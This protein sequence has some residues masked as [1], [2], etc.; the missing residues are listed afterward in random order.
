VILVLGGCDGVPAGAGL[1][2][3]MMVTGAQFSPGPMPGASG[4]PAV[5]SLNLSSNAVRAG[6]I[7]AP[8]SGALGP[9][10]T[11]A[12]LGLRGDA[13][14]WIVPAGLPDVAAPSYPTFNVSL[15][16]SASLAP[17]T[18]DL[19]VQAV[20]ADGHFGAPETETLTATAPPG[21]S[22]AMVVTL[23][24]DTEADLDLH[25]VDPAGRIVWK[26]DISPAG[27]GALLDFDSNAGC[28]VDGRR[29]ED[30]IWMDP[31]MS[32]RYQV[33]VD[34]FSLCAATFADWTV[35]VTLQ[36]QVVGRAAGESVETDAEVPHDRGAGVLALEI[37]VP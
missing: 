15:S 7:E 27:S 13:G 1:G 37:D 12:S 6:E 35:E 26:G 34:T 25:V 32:G 17:G 18:Y 20:D 30:V 8:V 14:Y 9:T 21:P 5:V 16:F 10:A 19:V 2:A 29:Q 28:V 3:E 11:A 33:L 22:G 24:W 36:G 31:P 4:G 23:R